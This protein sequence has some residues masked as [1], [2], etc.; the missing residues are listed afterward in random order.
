MKPL[1]ALFF[2]LLFS[3][4]AHSEQ[5]PFE[6]I[7]FP[8]ADGL[9]ISA[10]LYQPHPKS[11]PF[12]VLFHQAKWSRGEYR[13]TAPK[14]NALGFNAMAVDQ[15]SGK[16]VNDVANLTAQRHGEP[17]SYLEAIP[18]MLAAIE[19][20]K[21]HYAS[22]KLIIWGSSYSSALSL[23]IAGD[24]PDI[25]DAVLAFSPGEYFKKTGPNREKFITNSAQNIVIPAFITSAKREEK[26]W[27]PIYQA[28]PGSKKQGFVPESAGNHGSRALWEQFEDSGAYWEAVRG[29]LQ[30]L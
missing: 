21:R 1:I 28:I 9:T 18:D 11:A 16:G 15:R 30:S 2:C 27:R 29:F 22:G 19:Y 23:K 24:Q 3:A 17:A 26:N 12:I 10:D 6:T 20:A 8:S 25:A 14:L 5:T 4:A 13:E 7:E